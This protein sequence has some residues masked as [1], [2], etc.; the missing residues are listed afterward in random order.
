MFSSPASNEK[1]ACHNRDNECY[2]TAT[3]SDTTSL[4]QSCLDTA[5]SLFPL[6]RIMTDHI[7]PFEDANL[8][9]LKYDPLLVIF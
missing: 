3:L 9:C 2:G 7:F 1:C 5:P 8:T 4:V 6:F